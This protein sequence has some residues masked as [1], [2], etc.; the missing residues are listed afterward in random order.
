MERIPHNFAQFKKSATDGV[1]VALIPASFT[2]PHPTL[3]EKEAYMSRWDD[4]GDLHKA[5]MAECRKHNTEDTISL[6]PQVVHSAHSKSLLMICVIVLVVSK[7][8][9]GDA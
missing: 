1:K 7:E 3:A 9:M 5:V 8:I 6:L 2:A 4:E